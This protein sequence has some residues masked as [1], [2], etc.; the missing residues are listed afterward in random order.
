MLVDFL[1]F[2]ACFAGATALLGRMIFILVEKGPVFLLPLL[3]RHWIAWR[4]ADVLALGILKAIG[5]RKFTSEYSG[6]RL[7]VDILV[8][9]FTG[10][11]RSSGEELRFNAWVRA[12]IVDLCNAVR[13][14]IE[15]E[16]RN[17]AHHNA[18]QRII[19]HIGQ[20]S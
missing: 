20:S 4:T 19:A 15:D 13:R 10:R 17:I 1:S 6:W 11:C 3:L 2:M 9:T 7:D 16:K 12:L 14:E 8:D 18:T 5:R